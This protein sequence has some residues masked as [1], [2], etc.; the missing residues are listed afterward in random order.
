MTRRLLNLLTA[1]SLILSLAVAALWV[2]AAG[3]GDQFIF[4][5]GGRFWWVVSA[6]SGFRVTT[7]GSWPARE[8]LRWMPRVMKKTNDHIPT[9]AVAEPPPWTAWRRLGVRGRHGMVTTWID[10]GGRP[11]TLSTYLAADLYGGAGRRS[12]LMPC[13]EV[14]V[15]YWVALGVCSALPLSHAAT[16][17][18]AARRRRRLRA[19]VRCPDCGYDLRATP[20]RCPECGGASTSH[21]A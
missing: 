6:R 14:Y 19:R 20:G 7:V 11:A 18:A 1:L 21:P 9:V 15:P 16:K 5:T 12:P 2:R 3:A 13:A 8:R 4:T 10:A 17:L